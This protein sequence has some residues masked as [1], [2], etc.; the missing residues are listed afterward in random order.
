MP[1]A[2]AERVQQDQGG[3][4]AGPDTSYASRIPF[5]V[6]AHRSVM[7]PTLPGRGG[8]PA[9]ARRDSAAASG[10]NCATGSAGGGPWGRESGGGPPLPVMH[11]VAKPSAP[12]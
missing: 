1:G 12:R 4:P 3:P 10:V 8:G 5:T 11:L 2:L 6:T 9:G 7:A